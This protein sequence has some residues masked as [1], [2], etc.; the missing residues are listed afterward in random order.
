MFNLLYKVSAYI[1]NIMFNSTNW[2]AV[3]SIIFINDLLVGI[4]CDTLDGDKLDQYDITGS[5]ASNPQ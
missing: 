4:R 3:R 1:S 2:T 5:E